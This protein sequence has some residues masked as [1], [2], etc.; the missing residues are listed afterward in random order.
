MTDSATA[1]YGARQ[2]SQGSN[3][4]TWGDDKLNEALRLFDRGSKGYQSLVMTGDTTLN[5]TNYVATNTGQCAVLKLT[6]SLSVAASLTVP[7]VEWTWDLI[8]NTTG[9]T[10]TLKTVAGTGVEI[11]TGRGLPIYC[12]G[13]DC[14]NRMGS[15]IPSAAS[16]AGGLSVAGAV[17]VAGKVSGVA[18]GIAGTDAVNKTQMEAAIATAAIP[19]TNGTMF[20]SSG[21]TL[22]GYNVQKNAMA[23]DSLLTYTTQNPLANEYQELSDRRL[24]RRAYFIGQV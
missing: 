7:S 24:R 8:A 5:W 12:D 17:T 13:V 10:I 18:A 4:N 23:S 2:Q 6:G 11:P 22:A 16:I 14:H 21:D 3:T 9:Q 15:N 19:A 20:N 1:R